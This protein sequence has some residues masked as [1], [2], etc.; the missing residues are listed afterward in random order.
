M[1]ESRQPVAPVG[2]NDTAHERPLLCRF[3]HRTL[4]SMSSAPRC[5]FPSPSLHLL[6]FFLAVSTSPSI[7]AAADASPPFS[8]LSYTSSRALLQ[9]GGFLGPPAYWDR[10]SESA[11]AFVRVT[12]AEAFRSALSAG[13]SHIVLGDHLTLDGGWSTLQPPGPASI[14]VRLEMYFVSREER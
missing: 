9:R 7:C 3:A 8:H 4:S 6:L 2:R 5:N 12:T 14:L 1:L 11:G 13:E 10:P